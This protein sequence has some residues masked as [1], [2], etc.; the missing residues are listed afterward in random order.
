[1]PG[2]YRIEWS[3]EARDHPSELPRRDQTT[4]LDRVDVHLSDQPT[5]QTRNRKLME[6][7]AFATWELRVGRYRVYYVV[8]EQEREV[9]VRGVGVKER[10]VVRIGGEVVDL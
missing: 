9:W 2:R 1:M 4:I 8:E 5:V 6:P 7:N 3:P 10:N